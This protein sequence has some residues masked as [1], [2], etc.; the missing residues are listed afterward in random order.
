ML[1]ES[2]LFKCTYSKCTWKLM[3]S[4]CA[5]SYLKDFQVKV[6]LKITSFC[7]AIEQS[8]LL[9]SGLRK[10]QHDILRVVLIQSPEKLSADKANCKWVDCSVR[11][12]DQSQLFSFPPHLHS[13]CSVRLSLVA[14]V[15]ECIFLTSATNRMHTLLLQKLFCPI[16]L[17]T[18]LTH[19][20]PMAL[21][22][23]TIRLWQMGKA[24]KY[25]LLVALWPLITD[26]EPIQEFLFLCHCWCAEGYFGL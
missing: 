26:M 22:L 23:H 11:C 13:V 17:S 21:K 4:E 16:K 15:L 24:N 14:C 7:K 5:T 6:M 8:P 10:G 19:N 1:I 12:L 9:T 2:L 20:S 18:L 3:R 25:S